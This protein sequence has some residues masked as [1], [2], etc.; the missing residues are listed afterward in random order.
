MMIFHDYN[1]TH[2]EIVSYWLELKSIYHPP[3]AL[4]AKIDSTQEQA[5]A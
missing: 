5:S 4:A 1:E 2:R 3:P